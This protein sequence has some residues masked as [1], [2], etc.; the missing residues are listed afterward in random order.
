M[1]QT[2]GVI[3]FDSVLFVSE[4]SVKNIKFRPFSY[5]DKCVLCY[6]LLDGQSNGRRALQKHLEGWIEW[7]K[8]FWKFYSFT[9]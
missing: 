9:A 6:V 7:K 3:G 1:E 4:S 8:S 2:E 5:I